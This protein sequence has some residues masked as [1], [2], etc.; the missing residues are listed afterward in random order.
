[1]T[2]LAEILES[3]RGES[4]PSQ[5]KS[6]DSI[7]Y[8]PKDNTKSLDY[9]D[10]FL[11]IISQNSK[12]EIKYDNVETAFI[13]MATGIITLPNYITND[14][15]M[16]ILMGS[17][18]V[19]HA[20]HTPKD[21]YTIHN[22][23]SNTIHGITLN[24]NLAM[25]INI[26][27]DIRIEKLIRAQFPGFVSVYKAGYK[28][29]LESNPNF[30]VTAAS[31]KKMSLAN[32]INVK[33]KMGDLINFPLTD[34]E[35]AVLKYMKTAKNFDDV[36]IRAVYLYNEMVKDKE[37]KSKDKDDKDDTVED[38]QSNLPDVDD[39]DESED[40][41]DFT[42]NSDAWEKS[43]NADDTS[44]SEST[45][46]GEGDDSESEDSVANEL[47]E[48]QSAADAMNSGQQKSGTFNKKMLDML[49]DLVNDIEE[50]LENPDT[51]EDLFD[52]VMENSREQYIKNSGGNNHK[53]FS[54]QKY[55][56]IIS[57]PLSAIL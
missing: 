48:A 57:N 22:S 50:S 31:W 26:V 37:D 24:R 38:S 16:Y 55:R 41:T 43:D 9:I 21:F 7:K 12:L 30:S 17:H 1:M 42:G 29:L 15:D 13:N 8:T 25:C 34:K 19:S 47:A 35:Y 4:K 5:D 56:K 11:R 54:R 39:K 51:T 44:S 45:S 36:V 52:D 33:S 53:V 40:S 28:K 46:D 3:I 6:I 10:T 32:K 23:K 14:R 2:T 18:E 27:E 49:N 20:L